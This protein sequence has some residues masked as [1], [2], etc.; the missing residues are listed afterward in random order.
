MLVAIAAGGATDLT[1]RFVAQKLTESL[2]VQVYVENK[3]G[4]GYIPALKDLTSAAPDGNTLLMISTAN[5]VAQRGA[6]AQRSARRS[7]RR[8]VRRDAGDGRAEQRRR[9]AVLEVLR[10]PRAGEHRSHLACPVRGHAG[11]RPT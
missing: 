10:V 6:G 2:K 1:A 5:L 8:N 11:Q 3:P 7:H 4:G 9:V